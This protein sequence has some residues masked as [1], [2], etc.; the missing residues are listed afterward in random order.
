MKCWRRR[1]K[2]VNEPHEESTE[3]T[4][5]NLPST[6]PASDTNLV[7][8]DR[9][10]GVE[11]AGSQFGIPKD[12]L[13]DLRS[14]WNAIQG[15][16]VDEPRKAVEDADN[17]VASTLQ[18]L[19]DRFQQECSNLQSQWVNDKDVSTEDLRLAIQ[20]YRTVFDRLILI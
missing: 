4:R 9:A 19:K 14:R 10:R 3:S 7:A 13:D 5:R 12:E 16:F 8:F 11:D 17:L 18:Q 15:K 2:N 1:M 6:T 20:R